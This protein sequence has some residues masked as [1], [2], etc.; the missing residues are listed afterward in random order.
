[1]GRVRSSAPTSLVSSPLLTRSATREINHCAE[2]GS[3][4]ILLIFLGVSILYSRTR[5]VSTISP[6]TIRRWL[7]QDKIKPWRYHAWQPSTDPQ[8]VEKATPVL[9]LYESASLLATQQEGVCCTDEKT[10]IQARQRLHETKAA[11]PGSPVQVA[12]R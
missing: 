6:S 9:D 3:R 2:H 8:F 1:M 5:M 12:D 10:S 11:V 7:R 4:F